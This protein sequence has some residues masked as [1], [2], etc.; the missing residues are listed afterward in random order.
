MVDEDRFLLHV[1]D[2]TFASFNQLPR[3]PSGDEDHA[4]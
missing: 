3:A 4:V 1:E 2:E